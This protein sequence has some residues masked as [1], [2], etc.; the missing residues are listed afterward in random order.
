MHIP[1]LHKAD[2]GGAALPYLHYRGG[3]SQMVFVHATGFVPGMWHPVIR[4]LAP[5][6]SVW[7]PFINDYRHAD[8]HDGGLDWDV[9]ARD[10][11]VFCEKM[12]IDAP[13][14][15]GHSMGATTSALAVGKYGVKARGVVLIEPIFLPE[16]YY[17]EQIDVNSIAL[18]AKSIKR[19]NHWKNEEEA[20]AYLKKNAFFKS[21]D[22][23]VLQ[24]Y[25]K[26]GMQRLEKGDLNL[27]CSPKNEAAIFVGSRRI[28]PWPF[29]PR[30]DCPTMIIEGGDTEYRSFIDTGKMLSFLPKGRF[31]AV[32]DAHHLVVMEKP[33][34]I[35]Q[36]LKTFI[37]AL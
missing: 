31:E 26:Y 8:P 21:W 22:E 10:L 13:V 30:I 7:A 25:F 19:R 36:I 29:L 27:V 6:H 33:R 18:A 35:L 32:P 23:E 37:A 20:W 3:E 4:E 28:N 9:I 12:A 14:L 16:D 15:V 34:E 1:A 24:L 2:I 5:T 11:S 17:A